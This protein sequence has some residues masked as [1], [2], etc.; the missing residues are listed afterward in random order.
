MTDE[1]QCDGCWATGRRTVNLWGYYLC[2]A[3]RLRV[4]LP[5]RLTRVIDFI[6][7]KNSTPPQA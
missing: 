2:W 5:R 6:D 1:F 7:R 4:A 3:C